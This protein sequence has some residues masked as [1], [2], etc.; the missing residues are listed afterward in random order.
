MNRK[1][2]GGVKNRPS[3]KGRPAACHPDRP[4]YAK[5]MCRS[6]YEKN[7]RRT[8]PEFAERQKKNN[9]QWVKQHIEQ[10]DV[11]IKPTMQNKTQLGNG[12]IVY[13]LT[14]E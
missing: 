8:N 4:L 13:G 1:R 2:K 14:I 12:R 10:N 6:C 9:Q 7:L 3:G 5:K 11:S